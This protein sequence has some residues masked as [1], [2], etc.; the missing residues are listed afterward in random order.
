VNVQRLWRQDEL[1]G[2]QGHETLKYG[3]ESRR[4]RNQEYAG[5]D[6]QESTRLDR[7]TLDIKEYNNTH[8]DTYNP[9]FEKLQ[10][11]YT[12]ETPP[13]RFTIKAE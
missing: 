2:S 8:I 5:E 7:P 10:D 3:H 6:R 1:H 12:R 11:F 4:T 9:I 13:L